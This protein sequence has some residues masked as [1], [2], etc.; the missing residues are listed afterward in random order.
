MLNSLV[1]LENLNLKGNPI[2]ENDKIAK[3]VILFCIFLLLMPFQ[4]C[5]VHMIILNIIT[6]G[7]KV[8]AKLVCVQCETGR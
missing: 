1:D 7:P 5:P 4:L 8:V 3:K 6:A 2:A